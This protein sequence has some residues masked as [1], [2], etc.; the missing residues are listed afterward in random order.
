M[1]GSHHYATGSFFP[2]HFA[3]APQVVQNIREN[4]Q[5][6]AILVRI[7]LGWGRPIT[8]IF[9]LSGGSSD[10]TYNN[11]A[12]LFMFWLVLW[13]LCGLDS[14]PPPYICQINRFYCLRCLPR[15]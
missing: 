3:L 10:R 4:D 8:I 9:E 11:T 6:G 14:G 5:K 7:M 12:D 15:N 1:E 13:S 2:K